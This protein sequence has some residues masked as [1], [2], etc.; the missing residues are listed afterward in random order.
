MTALSRLINTAVLWWGSPLGVLVTAVVCT[1][2][3][4]YFTLNGSLTSQ[5]QHYIAALSE[6][7]I[8]AAPMIL[9]SGTVST[10]AIQIKLDGLIKGVAEV[11]DDL[12]GIEELPERE[13]DT[14]KSDLKGD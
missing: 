3:H 13:L 8:L 1:A 4:I 7:A 2:G 10:K 11:S 12:A 14:L 9:H 6:F 5:F